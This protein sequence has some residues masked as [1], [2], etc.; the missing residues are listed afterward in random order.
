MHRDPRTYDPTQGDIADERARASAREGEL[1]QRA[2]I[3]GFAGLSDAELIAVLC[4]SPSTDIASIASRAEAFLLGKVGREGLRFVQGS[5]VERALG[6]PNAAQRFGSARELGRR[7]AR[8]DLYRTDAKPTPSEI[9]EYLRVELGNQ[10]QEQFVVVGLSSRCQILSLRTVALGTV[11]H[12]DVHPREVFR[13]LI[14]VAAHAC[15]VAHNHPSGEAHASRAD[16]DLTKRLQ[17]AGE[18]MGIPLLDH[19]IVT[20]SRVISLASIG[21]LSPRT[22]GV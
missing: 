2:A 17:A 9:A 4:A 12:V 10:L 1:L 22:S 19:L 14:E 8:P 5:A 13:N 3:E 6:C 18:L 11:S 20:Q 15:I 16:V 7:L 21:M